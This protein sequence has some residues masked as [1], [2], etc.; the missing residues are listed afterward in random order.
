MPKIGISTLF[1]RKAEF[2]DR[3]NSIPVSALKRSTKMPRFRKSGDLLCLDRVSIKHE[4][5]DYENVFL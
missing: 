5:I 2:L 3:I 4:L 1:G